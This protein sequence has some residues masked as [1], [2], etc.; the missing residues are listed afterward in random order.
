MEDDSQASLELVSSRFTLGEQREITNIL[1]I[2]DGT[3]F[4]RFVQSVYSKISQIVC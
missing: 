2:F 4:F 1:Q 3:V